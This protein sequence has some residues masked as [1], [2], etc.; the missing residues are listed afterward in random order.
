MQ[1]NLNQQSTNYVLQDIGQ[2]TQS[3]LFT[4]VLA[5]GSEVQKWIITHYHGHSSSQ[6]PNVYLAIIHH[7]HL[8][9]FVCSPINLTYSIASSH[10]PRL[11]Q[12]TK[13]KCC[14]F[15]NSKFYTSLVTAATVPDNTSHHSLAIQGA[16]YTFLAEL[17]K[18][19]Q[20]CSLQF[21][22]R[23]RS[24]QSFPCSNSYQSTRQC[25][26]MLVCKCGTD[27]VTLVQGGL[28]RAMMAT[29]Y[30]QNP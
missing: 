22:L 8:R 9:L 27:S 7:Y 12:Q 17:G 30:Y 2:V 20:L 15:F 16:Y 13:F 14:M 21:Q 19:S 6:N 29:Q 24:N 5:S 18:L 10:S 28:A 1:T 3:I 25:F 11:S 4:S 23:Y 26:L